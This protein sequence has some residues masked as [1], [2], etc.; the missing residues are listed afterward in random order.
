MK[1]KNEQDYANMVNGFNPTPNT[2]IFKRCNLDPHKEE[3]RQMIIDDVNFKHIGEHFDCSGPTIKNFVIKIW[4]DDYLK[5]LKT[6]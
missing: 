2:F 3:I 6:N 4:G 5:I 1:N